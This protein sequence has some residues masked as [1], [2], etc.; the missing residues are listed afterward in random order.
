M[1]VMNTILTISPFRDLDHLELDDLT[2]PDVIKLPNINNNNSNKNLNNNINNNANSNN[3]YVIS[4]QNSTNS[5]KSSIISNVKVGVFIVSCPTRWSLLLAFG[6]LYWS[7]SW[8]WQPHIAGC[9]LFRP[10][11]RAGISVFDHFFCKMYFLY[12]SRSRNFFWAVFGGV[13]PPQKRCFFSAGGPMSELRR[14]VRNEEK[15]GNCNEIL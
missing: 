5:T 4:D 2:I 12:V 6:F 1:N 11:L 14:N 15:I 9:K 13:L 7:S 8:W 3:G 10:L